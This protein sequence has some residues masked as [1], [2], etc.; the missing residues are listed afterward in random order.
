MIRMSIAS[1]HA[2]DL[3]DIHYLLGNP[4]PSLSCRSFTTTML[5]NRKGQSYDCF[6][7]KIGVYSLREMYLQC[8]YLPPIAL[9]LHTTCCRNRQCTSYPSSVIFNCLSEITLK[10]WQKIYKRMEESLP[11][12]SGMPA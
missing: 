12:H 1:L 3:P 11:P 2:C 9:S 6:C 10:H 7:I 4:L 5:D 8:S